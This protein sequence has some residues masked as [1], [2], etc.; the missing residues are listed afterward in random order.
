LALSQKKHLLRF[1]SD[2]AIEK[3]VTDYS[4]TLSP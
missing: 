2:T 4:E 3:P 1:V